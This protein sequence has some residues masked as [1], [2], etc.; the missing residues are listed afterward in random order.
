MR[1][2]SRDPPP[3]PG[4]ALGG[5]GAR[6]IRCGG[7]TV[8]RR[9]F[10]ALPWVAPARAQSDPLADPRRRIDAVDQR[11]VA[12][13]NERAKIV[14]E[15]SRIKKAKNLPVSDPRRFREV[16]DKAA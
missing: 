8:I 6:P 14:D 7:P 12:L 1:R 15:V 11:L 16:V 9:L 13:L 3:V 2:S 4:A 5:P 10:L